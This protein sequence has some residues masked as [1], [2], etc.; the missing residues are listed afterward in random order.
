MPELRKDPITGRWVIIATERAK[1]PDDFKHHEELKTSA[2]AQVCQ[3]CPGNEAMTPQEVTVYRDA[4]T[5]ANSPGWWTRVVPNKFPA[6]LPEGELNRD[7][8]GMYDMM[9]GIGIHDVI[10][11][12][13][14]HDQPIALM[15]Q[16]QV[17]EILWIYRDRYLALKHDRRL[18]YILIFKN[19]GKAAGASL[20]HPHSQLIATPIIPKWVMNELEGSQS[21]YGFKERCVYC[22]IIKEELFAKNRLV[23]ENQNFVAFEPYASRFPFETWIMPKK[24][25]SDYSYIE[26]SEIMDLAEILRDILGRIYK[27]LN[28]PPY[29]YI[30]HTTPLEWD[31]KHYYHWHIEIMPI[32]TKMAGFEWGTGMY[33]NPTVPEQAAQ[34]LR[35]VEAKVSN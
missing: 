3:L 17:E 7:G 16:R 28:N 21:Y 35:E 26:K 34:S 2:K 29:N 25:S 8:I 18:K 6:L 11:E 20:E 30:L 22:D 31:C 13:P 32:L 27:L 1:R 15:S 14:M 10:I 33:I 23:M 24:H 9:N 4:G 19:H 12:T 5:S